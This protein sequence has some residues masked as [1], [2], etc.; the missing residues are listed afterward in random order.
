MAQNDLGSSLEADNPKKVFIQELRVKR[1]NCDEFPAK[2]V[3][4]LSHHH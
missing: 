3:I 1:M 2:V 4:R